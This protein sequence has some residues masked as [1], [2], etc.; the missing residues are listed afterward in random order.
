MHSTQISDWDLEDR[1]VADHRPIVV[2]FFRTGDLG[3]EVARGEFGFLADK[4]PESRFYELDL[5]E[6]PSLAGKYGLTR[7]NHAPM[8]V[9]MVF[10]DGVEQT[11]HVGPLLSNTIKRIL[12]PRSE[13][14]HGEDRYA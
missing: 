11:R 3:Q 9:T 5:L 13:S 4:Y 8:P 6:N 2:Q 12:G 10:V 1:M 7:D 14:T